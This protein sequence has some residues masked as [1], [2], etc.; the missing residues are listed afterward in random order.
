VSFS[1]KGAEERVKTVGGHHSKSCPLF[2]RKESKCHIMNPAGANVTMCDYP[3]NT[4]AAAAAETAATAEMMHTPRN[5]GDAMTTPRTR[6]EAVE[7]P[8]T[9]KQPTVR[10]CRRLMIQVFGFQSKGFG[11][12]F[13]RFKGVECERMQT[14]Y[15]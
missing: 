15:G 2:I 4:A 1:F 9:T 8:S 6:T 3:T 7:P 13:W 5:S 12:N 10:E 14:I 11:D